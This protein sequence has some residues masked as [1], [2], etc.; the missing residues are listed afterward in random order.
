MKPVLLPPR[1]VQHFYRGG[2][3][4]A[5]LRGIEPETDRQPEEW[6]A[7]TVSR[8]GSDDIGLAVTD[9]GAYLRDLVGADRA[10]WVG[11]RGGRDAADLGILV[12]LLDARQRLPV[13]VH[14]DRGFAASHLDCPYGKTEAW[15]VLETED[16]CAVHLGWNRPVD[17]DELDRRR[18]AQDGEWMLAHMNRIVVRPGMGVLVP[19]GTVHAIDGGIFLAEVQEPTDFSILLEWSVTTSTCEE[20]HLD[21][22]F[23]AVMPAVST[24][25]LDAAALDALISTAGTAP[26]EAGFRSL[27]PSAADPYFRLFDAAGETAPREAGFA[28]VLV[29]D[30]AGALVSEAGSV[31]VERGQV[32]AV[33]HAFGAWRL[34]GAAEVLVAAPGAGWPMT[35]RGGDVR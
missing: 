4:I 29:S 3:R 1:P 7:S 8:F 19:A 18:E 12:K 14:P 33:P 5:A 9:D 22:G 32:Y 16:H 31:D 24:D 20:S 30:G 2:D 35:L 15:Y 26:A 17:R 28:V 23:D 10:A 25:A 13:H 6:L 21:L 11:A 34:T 27:L